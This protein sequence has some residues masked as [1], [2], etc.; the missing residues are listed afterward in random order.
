MPDI[1]TD[2]T[3]GGQEKGKLGRNRVGEGWYY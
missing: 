2:G 1:L 3:F